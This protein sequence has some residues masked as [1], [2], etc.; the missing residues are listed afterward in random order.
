MIKHNLQLARW[1][2]SYPLVVVFGSFIAFFAV[3]K[4][5]MFGALKTLKP[6]ILIWDKSLTSNAR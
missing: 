6:F 2:N 1:K 4:A 5:V 3:I